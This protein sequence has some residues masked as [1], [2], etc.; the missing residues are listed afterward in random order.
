M[1]CYQFVRYEMKSC[2][3][4]DFPVSIIASEVAPKVQA[5]HK[6]ASITCVRKKRIIA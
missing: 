4:K 2:N 6:R 5:I 1:K 3:R